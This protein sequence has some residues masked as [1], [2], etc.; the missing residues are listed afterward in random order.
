[1]SQQTDSGQTGG[2]A[3]EAAPQDEKPQI[4]IPDVIPVIASGSTVMYPQQLMPVLATDEREIKAVDDAAAAEVQ[5][6]GLFP[7]KEGP[8]EGRYEG[9]LHDVGIAANIVRMAK[10]PDGSVHAI[11]QGVA[12]IRLLELVQSEPWMRARVE[13]L[14][15]KVKADLEAEAL[16]RNA[17]AAFQ[18]VVDI[19]EA[20]PKEL[21]TAVGNVSE[22]SSLA[23]FIAANLNI[24]PEQR[25][26]ALE[27][28]DVHK[29]LRLIRRCW[30][31]SPA[32]SPR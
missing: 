3:A 26:R 27:E 11:I 23:D 8:E 10:A 22:P 18:Q 2:R 4:R 28:L 16:M 25:Q 5:I 19:S 17:V 13:R 20:L 7:Q 30:R 32:S 15:E 21:A 9:D 14:E 29:R 6:V 24:T 31:S 1:M 12:R